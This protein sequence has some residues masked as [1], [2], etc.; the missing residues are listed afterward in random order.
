M[1]DNNLV[2]IGDVIQ[3]RK[4]FEPEDWEYFHESIERL[5][6]TFQP[7]LKIPFS[8]Y[9]G[10]SFGAVCKDLE[11]SLRIVLAIQEFQRHQNSRIILIE[12]RITF[13]MEKK[14]F[15]SLEG[16]ALW[17]SEEKLEQL[18]EKKLIFLAD[19]KDP[20]I[21]K[22]INITIGLIVAIRAGWNDTEWQIYKK[23]P[24]GIR[25]Q[26]IANDLGISQQYVS[27]VIQSSNINLVNT[28][29]NELLAL[30]KDI[31]QENIL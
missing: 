29:E 10:D 9:S 23:N 7:S 1:T 11:S 12:D 28:S 31:T 26:E 24:K 20:F 13:G 8:I 14:S 4:K 6:K 22:V 5:N 21:T 30:V 3:S 19:L 27:K 15:L 17:R 25:Q 16:P 2:I 18:K